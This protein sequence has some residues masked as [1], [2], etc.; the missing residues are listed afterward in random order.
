MTFDVLIRNG[1]VVDGTGSAPRRADVGINGERIAAVGELGEAEGYDEIDAAGRLITPGFIDAHAHSDV[2]LYLNPV[3][4]TQ[5]GQGITTEVMGNCG[6]SPFPLLDRNRG[7]LL[8]P[9]GVEVLPWSTAAE[10]FHLMDDRGTGINAVP[11]VGH[12]TLRKAVLDG[13]DRPA[14]AAE[15]GQMKGHVRDAMEAGARG[16]SSGLDYAPTTASD[17]DE[18]VDLVDVVAEYGGFYSSHI[19]GYSWNV[20]NAV[21]ETLEVGRRTGVT[22]QISH[23]NIYGRKHWG[24]MDRVMALMDHARRDGIKVAC[25]MMP[26]PTAGA[27]WSPRAILPPE[28]Y[29]WKNTWAENLPGLESL[30]SDPRKRASL[31]A[32]IED[33]RTR[34]KRGFH[35]EFAIFGDW[36]DIHIV[37]LPAVSPRRELVGLNMAT[38]SDSVGQDPCDLYFDLILEE[39]EAFG[40]ICSPFDERD[41]QALMRDRWTLFG[42]D[43]IGSSLSRLDEP[44]NNIQP[45]PR[46]TGTFPRLLGKFVRDEGL[47]EIGDAIRRMSGLAADH[48]GLEGRGYV[49]KGGQADLVVAALETVGERAT[50]RLPSAYPMGID[51]VFVNGVQAVAEGEFTGKLGGRILTRSGT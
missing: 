37:E 34:P 22:I 28:V 35:E 16:L 21:A 48:L 15:I 40:A 4:E 2:G 19:R 27:W 33:R 46:H 24:W 17:L 5:V 36:R 42:T 29:D 14:N 51:Y 44:W 10:Y 12:L 13:E 38:A 3:C 31:K 18:M 26:Y 41:F 30:L 25:D 50:W 23:L 45:H 1:Q 43:A 7:L 8:D 20:L 6:Y 9:P 39:G 11:Q 49:R 32:E 47:L